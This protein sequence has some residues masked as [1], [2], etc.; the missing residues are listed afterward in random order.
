[1]FSL[2][3]MS[4]SCE[5]DPVVPE[6][7]GITPDGITVEDLL[8]NWNFESL[9]IAGKTYTGGCSVELDN[10]YNWGAISLIEINENELR[11]LD[12]CSGGNGVSDG[13]SLI[14]NIINYSKGK[15]VFEITNAD[16]FNGT[17]LKLEFKSSN[18]AINAPIGGIYTL[19]HN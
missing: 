2:V 8:G 4:T 5:K 13:Y 16:T 7:D 15:F 3:L 6:P 17:V 14:D 18:I 10:D 11:L 19:R 12:I 9:E 1:M